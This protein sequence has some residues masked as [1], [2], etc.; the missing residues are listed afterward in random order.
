MKWHIPPSVGILYQLLFWC[1]SFDDI[2]CLAK[3]HSLQEI[4]LDGNP[5][6][7]DQFYKQTILSN[8]QQL[9]QLDMKRVTVSESCYLMRVTTL[10]NTMSVVYYF[11]IPALILSWSHSVF[12]L[13]DEEKRISAVMARKEDDRRRELQ[14][15]SLM[16]VQ[17]TIYCNIFGTK[18][19]S[20]WL[21]MG[22]LPIT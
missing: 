4:S 10:Y 9:K 11:A 21:V 13:K 7:S 20:W 18:E 12:C 3:S 6:A 14:K 5:I 16:K 15:I 17:S 22:M 8:M 2:L 1:Y 19:W